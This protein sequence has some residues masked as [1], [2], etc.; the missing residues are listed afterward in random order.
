[1]KTQD[2]LAR[3]NLSNLLIKLGLCPFY[4]IN[5]VAYAASPSSSKFKTWF[6]K[7]DKV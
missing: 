3:H 5:G 4:I 7:Y 1:M 6:L 2:N